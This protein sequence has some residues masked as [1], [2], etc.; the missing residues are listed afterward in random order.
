M[1]EKT[2]R[3]TRNTT[4]DTFRLVAAFF[5]VT[6]HLFGAKYWNPYSNILA[7]TF[8]FMNRLAVP[9][10]F[11]VTGYFLVVP[12]KAVGQNKRADFANLTSNITPAH[13]VNPVKTAIAGGG[14]Y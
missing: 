13:S 2:S 6:I 4:I 1:P 11:V 8:Y 10:F 12:S 5:V 9:F 7:Q 14:N 3:S